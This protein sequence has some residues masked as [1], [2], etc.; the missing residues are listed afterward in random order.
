MKRRVERNDFYAKH[1]EML[2]FIKVSEDCN[3][4]CTFCYQLEKSPKVIDTESKLSLA[5]KNLQ[6]GIDRFLHLR[7]MEEYE[8]ANLTICYFGG[9]CTTNPWAM[10]KITEYLINNVKPYSGIRLTL[11]TNGI[12]FNDEI[13]EVLTNMNEFNKTQ[14]STTSLLISSD[15]DKEVYDKNRKVVGTDESGYDIVSRHI[16]E[17]SEFLFELNYG[18][19]PTKSIDN[20]TN[21]VSVSAVLATTEQ[22]ENSRENIQ[23]VFKGII[24]R[25][26]ILYETV[27]MGDDYIQ[28]AREFLNRTYEKIIHKCEDKSNRDRALTEV[29]NIVFLQN[30]KLSLKE[31]QSLYTIDGNGEFNW[32]NKNKKFEGREDIPNEELGN[33]T[34]FNSSEEANNE[35]FICVKDK[36]KRGELTKDKNSV[37]LWKVFNRYYSNSENITNCNIYSNNKDRVYYFVKYVMCT[38][39]IHSVNSVYI[40]DPEDRVRDICTEYGIIIKDIPISMDV[41]VFHIDSSGDL[42]LDKSVSGDESL[43]LSNINNK[44]FIFLHVPSLIRSVNIYY[45]T[46][47][48]SIN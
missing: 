41:P 21:L 23:S 19:D 14:N 15:N 18:D 22:I 8:F 39:N 9:E 5:L 12:I 26:G 48:N 45:Q 47:L 30:S 44:H 6:F 31:C 34:V 40:K 1:D 7:S 42:Y 36:Y 4:R 43:V 29:L 20:A 13:K 16:K 2:I 25:E 27:S 46:K 11:T 10:N 24:R 3:M 17:Y 37:N 35:H 33:L 32:C 38:S 28:S